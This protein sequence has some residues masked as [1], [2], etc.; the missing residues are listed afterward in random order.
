MHIQLSKTVAHETWLIAFDH[1]LQGMLITHSINHRPESRRAQRKEHEVGSH[2]DQ[3]LKLLAPPLQFTLTSEFFSL[4]SMAN[5]T[6]QVGRT[7]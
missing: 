3:G 7:L 5:D 1:E 4:S 2:V 6:Y